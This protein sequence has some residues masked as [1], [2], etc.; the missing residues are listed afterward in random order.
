MPSAKEREL[1]LQLVCSR[2]SRIPTLRLNA[3]GPH[4]PS[5]PQHITP[6]RLV[7]HIS[8]GVCY[9]IRGAWGA[10]SRSNVT[11]KQFSTVMR[12]SPWVHPTAGFLLRCRGLAVVQVCAFSC[13][14]S[15][16]WNTQQRANGN[17]ADS[18]LQQ[19]ASATNCYLPRER[20]V[21][22]LRPLICFK[23]PFPR[24]TFHSATQHR[25]QTPGLTDALEGT[26][27]HRVG[28]VSDLLLL[29][30]SEE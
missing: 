2:P 17:Y 20:N 11:S 5:P 27:S 19:G 15:K 14:W 23:Y 24:V 30:Q 13:G 22:R 21:S 7:D 26:V 28:G 4:Q 6:L 10:V 9:Q 12:S 29:E 25:C 3:L 8:N 16:Q 1:T 18:L